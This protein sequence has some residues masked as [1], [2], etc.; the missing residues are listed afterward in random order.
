[1]STEQ[2]IIEIDDAIVLVEPK[3][4]KNLAVRLV[5][6]PLI[7]FRLVYSFCL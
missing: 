3:A 6:L 1:M 5:V 2:G 7:F 4:E